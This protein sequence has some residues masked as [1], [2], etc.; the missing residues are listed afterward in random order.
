MVY[1]LTN[2]FIIEESDGTGQGDDY[3]TPEFPDY[4]DDSNDQL[5][6]YNGEKASW[7]IVYK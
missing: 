6:N 4:S 7:L 5:G 2:V 3:D 1:N